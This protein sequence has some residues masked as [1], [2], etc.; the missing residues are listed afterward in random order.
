MNM[1]L[2][3]KERTNDRRQDFMAQVSRREATERRVVSN[4][5]QI[6]K[7]KRCV[8][9]ISNKRYIF[10]HFD[11]LGRTPRTLQGGKQWLS[12]QEKT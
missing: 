10:K 1:I 11:S 3:T 7:Y 9:V 2:Q 12:I 4:Y 5:S 6:W 8:Y